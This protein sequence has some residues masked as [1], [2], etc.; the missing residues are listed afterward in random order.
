MGDLLAVIVVAGLLVSVGGGVASAAEF[1]PDLHEEE[2]D[3]DDTVLDVRLDADGDATWRIEHR[4]RLD[5]D[6]SEAAFAA[7]EEEIAEDPDSYEEDFRARMEE[8]VADAAASTGRSMA[9]ENVSVHTE[10]RS[11]PS[12]YGVVRYEFTWSGFA[13]GDASRLEAGD[14][15]E[16][17]FLDESSNLR[18]AWPDGYAAER[19]EPEPDEAGDTAVVWRGPVEFGEGEPGVTVAPQETATVEG[20]GLGPLVAIALVV[21]SLAVAGF[22]LRRSR[23]DGEAPAAPS[24]LLSNEERVLRLLEAEGGRMKQQEIVDRLEWTDAKTSQ[25]ISTL[26]QEDRLETFRLGRE[27]VVRLPDE[28]AND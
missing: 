8:S 5:D 20:I 17:L 25:V 7:L 18:I 23:D 12:D 15:I 26:R 28:G 4:Y 22:R 13:D 27:N 9:V 10:R 16:R 2:F 24:E 3:P 1:A 21:G 14:A 6:D 11:L 19:V